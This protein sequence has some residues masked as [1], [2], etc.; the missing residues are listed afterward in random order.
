MWPVLDPVSGWPC[1]VVTEQNIT[2]ARAAPLFGCILVSMYA[3]LAV[4]FAALRDV[5]SACQ[6]ADHLIKALGQNLCG[7]MARKLQ[8]VQ[9]PAV[10]LFYALNAINGARPFTLRFLVARWSR[11]CSSACA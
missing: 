2:Q 6:E 4:C 8:A 9:S 11:H 5:A 3:Y 7:A 1:M 10:A